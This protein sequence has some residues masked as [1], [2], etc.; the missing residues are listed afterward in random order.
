MEDEIS[1]ESSSHHG[2]DPVDGKKASDAGFIYSRGA[3]PYLILE[4]ILF[5][6][7]ECFK[8]CFPCRK[9]GG[10]STQYSHSPS[11]RFY[12]TT[13]VKDLGYQAIGHLNF[14]LNWPLLPLTS[15]LYFNLCLLLNL[16]ICVPRAWNLCYGLVHSTSPTWRYKNYVILSISVILRN[17]NV[18]STETTA[19]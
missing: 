9:I 10:K 16:E 7:E 8:S 4:N 5:W 13:S 1:D 18:Y 14:C 17:I 19:K 3:N 15:S 2:R 6:F 11:L 12:M